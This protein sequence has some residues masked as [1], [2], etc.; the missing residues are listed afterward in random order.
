MTKRLHYLL[1][2]NYSLLILYS[3]L[4]LLLTYPLA[5]NLTTAVP[6]DIGDPLLNT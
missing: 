4:A 5:L 6:N 2:T 3:L 1:I